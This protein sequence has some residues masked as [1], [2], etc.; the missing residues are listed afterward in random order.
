[1]IAVA[2]VVQLWVWSVIIRVVV[3]E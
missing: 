2:V 1:V 3:S